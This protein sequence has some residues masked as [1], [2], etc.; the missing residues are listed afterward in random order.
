MDTVASRVVQ[1][2][3]EVKDWGSHLIRCPTRF[4]SSQLRAG[5]L[6]C[7]VPRRVRAAHRVCEHRQPPAAG[8]GG[9]SRQKEKSRP[10]AM[11]ASQSRLLLQ[12][13]SGE[14][15]AVAARRR[16]PES[17]CRPYGPSAQSTP[18]CPARAGRFRRSASTRRPAVRPEGVTVRAGVV[19]GI[20][21][22]VG[23]ERRPDVEHA[24][25]KQS[26][27]TSGGSRSLLR[28]RAGR[29]GARAGKPC[30]SRGWIAWAEPFRTPARAAGFAASTSDEFQA[31]AAGRT[32][33]G[34]K[35]SAFYRELLDSLVGQVPV[36]STRRFEAASTACA[37]NYTTR[38]QSEAVGQISPS[39]RH[40]PSQSTGDIVSPGFISFRPRGFRCF[41]GA[42]SIHRWR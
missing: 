40:P 15:R 1:Q 34:A 13:L 33:P 26:A 41:P 37:G 12:L 29:R 2:Y 23:T 22:R 24:L 18:R 11:G 3:P 5:L 27:P 20:D 36:T 38:R 31:C 17:S 14:C 30:C 35:G 19:F 8:E 9:L 21:A 16:A 7:S 39:R 32:Y 25:L 28:Q 42:P 6:C 4:V 10:D